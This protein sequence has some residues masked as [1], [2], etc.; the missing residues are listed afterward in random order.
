V[1]VPEQQL[2]D[3]DRAVDIE[4]R[5]GFPVEVLDGGGAQLVEDAPDRDAVVGVGVTLVLGGDQDAAHG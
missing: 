2:I 1:A 5:L 3:E 4:D